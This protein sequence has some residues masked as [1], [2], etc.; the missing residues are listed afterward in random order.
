MWTF[1]GEVDLELKPRPLSLA[2]Q[3]RIAAPEGES[4]AL[5]VWPLVVGAL[6]VTPAAIAMCAAVLRA[7]LGLPSAFDAISLNPTLSL[8]VTASL[9]LGAPLAVILCFLP[10]MQWHLSRGEGKVVTGLVFKPTLVHLV[11]GGVALLVVAVFFGHLII[12]EF[13]CWRGIT[14]AC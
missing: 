4:S 5:R 14:S 11:I 9:F 7:Q 2:G 12:D 6:L 8:I 3:F 10:M 13:A 1:V